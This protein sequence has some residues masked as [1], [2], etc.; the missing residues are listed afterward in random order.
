MVWLKGARVIRRAQEPPAAFGR[1]PQERV[2]AGQERF[3]E[4]RIARAR[5]QPKPAVSNDTGTRPQLL[6]CGFRRID[7]SGLDRGVPSDNKVR[8][9]QFPRSVSRAEPVRC[10]TFSVNIPSRARSAVVIPDIGLPPCGPCQAP[11]FLFSPPALKQLT[12]ACLLLGDR[13]PIGA[14]PSLGART[15]ERN[16]VSLRKVGSA[17]LSLRLIMRA[18][19]D[20]TKSL[21]P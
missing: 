11:S 10:C 6:R 5:R 18:P 2:N 13:S 20:T 19:W 17:A 7:H 4:A 3:R 16:F 9:N 8:A 12:N 15:G 14:C 21:S 1:A